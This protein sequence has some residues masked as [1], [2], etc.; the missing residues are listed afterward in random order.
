MRELMV[1]LKDQKIGVL[2][3]L[4]ADKIL[5][6]FT[7]EYLSLSH[8]D[9]P[10]LSQSFFQKDLSLVPMVGPTQT[11]APAYF[12]NLLPEGYLREYLAKKAGINSVRDFGLL[13]LLGQDLPG[14]VRLELPQELLDHLEDSPELLKQEKAWK[15]EDVLKFSLAGVQLKLSALLGPTGGLTIPAHGLG[16]EWIV[17][18]PSERFAGVPEN[19]FSMLS[20]ARSIGISVPE[21]KLIKVSEIEGLP[22]TMGEFSG[23]E[24]MALAVKRFDRSSD[25]IAPQRIHIEDF[26]QV[27]GVYPEKKYQG[28]SY[29]NLAEMISIAAGEAEAYEFVKRLVF[30]WLIGNGDMHLKNWSFIYPDGKTPQLAPAYDYVSTVIF[31]NDHTFGLSLAGEKDML[32]MGKKQWER[33]AEKAKLSSRRVLNIVQETMEITLGEWD[34]LKKNSPMESVF[35]KKLEVHMQGLIKP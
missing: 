24:K 13:R 31:M 23:A 30:N 21:I 25:F 17:K 20:L 10:I 4:P 26:A 33:F 9:R 5:F 18:L 15:E 11:K 28:V 14:A 34:I 16:G 27:Y 8:S 19:E 1:Y 2:T 6:S 3:L 22:A 32:A 35:I 12:S 7:E 29:N